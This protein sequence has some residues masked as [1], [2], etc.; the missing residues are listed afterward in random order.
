MLSTVIV[1]TVSLFSS[2]L[3]AQTWIPVRGGINF[4]I[5]GMA[6]VEETE[7]GHSFLIAHDNKQPDQGFLAIV[8]LQDDH[9]PNY[10]PISF[11]NHETLPVDL[12]GLTTVPGMANHYMAMTSFGRVYHFQLDT[13]NKAISVINIFELPR[14]KPGTNLEGFALQEIDNKLV[15]VWA[16]R[17]QND[18]PG[19]VYWGNLDLDS[20]TLIP[21][22]FASLKVPYPKGNVRHISDIKVDSTGIVYISSAT[23]NGDNG[24]FESAVYGVGVLTTKNGRIAFKSSSQLIPLYR[25]HYH[26]IE[27]IAFVSG[28]LGGMILGT[29]DENMGASIW[30]TL[31]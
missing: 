5:S 10:T 13:E 22:G 6:L 17:G 15:A 29:D 9:S 11:P 23:D 7:N 14:L 25:Y 8:S 27:A 18:D 28:E 30:T 3:L 4:G 19:V 16:H 31:P 26:K 24:P 12:E 20:Y 1:G 21:Q 2:P